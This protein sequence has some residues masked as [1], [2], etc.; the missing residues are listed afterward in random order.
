MMSRN[1]SA[2][3]V[4]R[5]K[6]CPP[7]RTNLLIASRYQCP[8]N[9]GQQPRGMSRHHLSCLAA[10]ERLGNIRSHGVGQI[11]QVQAT[12]RVP[13]ACQVLTWADRIFKCVLW[14][15]AA[16]NICQEPPSP[17]L[18]FPA[19]FVLHFTEKSSFSKSM[20]LLDLFVLRKNVNS[21]LL[22]SS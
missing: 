16:G 15:Q 5:R 13:A 4:T 10:G 19:L 3:P 17:L 22:L 20:Y 1:G 18:I 12:F 14:F 9:S 11:E 2:L 7:L 21:K 8:G 6:K